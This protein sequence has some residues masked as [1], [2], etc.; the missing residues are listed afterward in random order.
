MP[1]CPKGKTKRKSASGKTRCVTKCTPHQKRSRVKNPHGG[2]CISRKGTG[3][4]KTAAKKTAAKKTAAKKTGPKKTGPKKTAAKKKPPCTP[5]PKSGKPRYRKDGRCVTKVGDRCK[6]G[7]KWMDG[8]C[9]KICAPDQVRSKKTNR[10]VKRCTRTKS[11]ACSKKCAKGGKF[12]NKLK[13]AHKYMKDHKLERSPLHS[14]RQD[15]LVGSF[16]EALC[17]WRSAAAAARDAGAAAATAAT[18]AAARDAAPPPPP[19]QRAASQQVPPQTRTTS[20]QRLGAP[21]RPSRS[22]QAQRTN[23]GLNGNYWTSS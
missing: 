7:Y 1:P 14:L 20:Q 17:S 6:D 22:L 5:H 23:T 19:P 10:C 16:Q 2:R 21:M 3:K 12:S 8:Q 18:A 4:K 15:L 13:Q 11:G 9:R